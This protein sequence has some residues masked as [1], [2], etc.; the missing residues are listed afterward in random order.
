MPPLFSK[1]MIPNWLTLLNLFCG[2]LAL[3]AVFQHH[4]GT[5]FLLL[6][7]GGWAD[8]FDGA[9]ARALGVHSP[10]GKELDSLADMVSFGLVPGAMLYTL[11]DI[12]TGGAHDP[13]TGINWVAAPAF[14]LTLFSCLR[15][16]KFNVDTRQADDFIGLATPSCTIFMTGLTLM[17]RNDTFGL[18]EWLTKPLV[19]YPIVLI[20]SYLLISEIRMFSFKLKSKAWKGNE[21][22][23]SFVILSLVLLAFLKEAA[24][25]I[26]IIIYIL[27]ALLWPVPQIQKK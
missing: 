5:A 17:Y 23:F 18:G 1:E 14:V 8:F 11:L 21:Q 2:S 12:G 25:P 20:F 9:V 26:A 10:I 27:M 24:L 4:F 15:L 19:I 16:A 6:F 22:R 3:V 7:I 13:A